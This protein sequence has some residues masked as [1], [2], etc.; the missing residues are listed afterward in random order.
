MVYGTVTQW[1]GL[2]TQFGITQNGDSSVGRV[3]TEKPGAILMRVRVPGEAR[4][5]SPRLNFQVSVQPSCAIAY[6]HQHLCMCMLKITSTGSYT[7]V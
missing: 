1:P 3:S 2:V 4:D 6:M 5:F 7:I